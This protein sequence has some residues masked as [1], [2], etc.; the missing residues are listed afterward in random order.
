MI[1]RKYIRYPKLF[2]SAVGRGECLNVVGIGT[3]EE[4]GKEEVVLTGHRQ[5]VT[6]SIFIDVIS[7]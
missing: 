4:M 7:L 3:V 6:R 2:S 5:G 1:G